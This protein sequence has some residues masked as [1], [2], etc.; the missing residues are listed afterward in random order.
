MSA[1]AANASLPAPRSTMQRSA[2]SADSASIT[3]ARSC[4]I[5]TVRALSFPGLLRLTVA[6]ASSRSTRMA[7]TPVTSHPSVMKRVVFYHAPTEQPPR[8]RGHHLDL[9]DKPPRQDLHVR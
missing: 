7:G 9:N 5:D 4:H 8:S 3:R 6:M 2:S 1:P